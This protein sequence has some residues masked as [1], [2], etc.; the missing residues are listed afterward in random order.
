MPSRVGPDATHRVS[1]APESAQVTGLIQ[2]PVV[3][4]TS[5][6]A[7]KLDVVAR[8]LSHW[9]SSQP[10]A[11]GQSGAEL[12]QRKQQVT[13]SAAILSTGVRI[14]QEQQKLCF[15]FIFYF[16]IFYWETLFVVF[17]LIKLV[18]KKKKSLIIKL[19]F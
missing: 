10:A 3:V 19:N 5:K 4:S 8:I 18:K 13:R 16:I 7:V 6:T 1:L 9:L 11:R 17:N 14:F 12:R 2:P 15:W